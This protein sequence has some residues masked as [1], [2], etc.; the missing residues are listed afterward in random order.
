MHVTGRS[1]CLELS[2]KRRVY[3][4]MH[5][6]PSILLSFVLAWH[7]ALAGGVCACFETDDH[8]AQD[9]RAD[10]HLASLDAPQQPGGVVPASLADPHH[11]E[12]KCNH[13][14]LGTVESPAVAKRS[15]T[16]VPDVPAL[17][18]GAS[19]QWPVPDDVES[20][21]I[22]GAGGCCTHHWLISV[23]SVVLLV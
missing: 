7:F 4:G 23:R 10:Q 19:T 21:S 1:P 18:D 15:K 16:Q 14:A 13:T 17:N 8:H 22:T 11:G 6:L 9:L 20:P 5:R 2:P 12:D 3:C